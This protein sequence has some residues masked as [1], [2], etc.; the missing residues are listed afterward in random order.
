[1]L[2]VLGLPG[3]N[4]WT[5]SVFGKLQENECKYKDIELLQ[6]WCSKTTFTKKNSLLCRPIGLLRRNI[7]YVTQFSLLAIAVKD[8]GEVLFICVWSHTHS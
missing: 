5:K 4:F 8:A 1:M 7:Y 6:K 2:L 3:N